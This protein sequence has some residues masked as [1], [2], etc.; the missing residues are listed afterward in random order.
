M[1]KSLS[2]LSFT[3]LRTLF[4]KQS[5]LKQRAIAGVF[6]SVATYGLGTGLRVGS[7]LIMTRL[8]FPEVFG[9]MSLVNIIIMGL[10]L[11]SDVGSAPT[12][13]RSDRGDDPELLNNVWT[14]QVIRGV[15]LWMGCLVLAVPAAYLYAEPKLY[16]LLPIVGLICISSGFSSTAIFTLSRHMEQRKRSLFDLQNQ[17]ISTGLIITIVWF[18][19]SIWGLVIGYLLSDLIQMVRSHFLISNY[20][21]RFALNWQTLKE[22]STFG[23]WILLS[24]MLTF[25]AGQVDRLLVGK[26]LSWHF[27]GIYTVV[28]TISEMPRSIIERVADQVIFPAASQLI[29]LPRVELRQ[30]LLHN[31]RPVLMAMALGLSLLVGIGDILVTFMYDPRYAPGAWMLPIVLLGIWPNVLFQTLYPILLALSK[32]QYQTWGN[33]GKFLFTGLGIPLGYAQFGVAGVIF[34]IALNDLPLYGVIAY[35]LWNE[36]LTSL[37]QDLTMTA[38]FVGMLASILSLRYALGFGFPIDRLW[39]T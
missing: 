21:N 20:R 3:N 39:M 13:I 23:R 10:H 38:F 32:P 2:K 28:M 4:E 35:G 9:L 5:V 16:W 15:M 1:F 14:I 6:W 25:L 22:M 29:E 26:M 18:S 37:R 12:V 31:R 17:I 30:K 33:A 19:R 36:K 11:F 24:T 8:L 27:L 34:V 7:S